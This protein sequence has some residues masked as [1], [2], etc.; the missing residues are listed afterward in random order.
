MR[1]LYNP[2]SVILFFILIQVLI[3]NQIDLFGYIDRL[4]YLILIITL[5]QST[6]KWILILY[7]FSIGLLLD[8]FEGNI[9]L[10]SSSLVFLSYIKPYL[11][12]I[13]IPKNSV[14]DKDSL[15][16]KNLGISIFS[17][18][19]FSLIFIH[20]IF[21]FMLDYFQSFDIL[22]LILKIIISSLISFIVIIIF[23]IFG[24]KSRN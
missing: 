2:I 20:N 6:P 9:G 13:T 18:H 12:K 3:L 15:N 10:N 23:Q 24:Y 8:L 14:E 7:G 4:V 22:F 17:L 5:P 11:E 1:I 16:L 19:A 21:L